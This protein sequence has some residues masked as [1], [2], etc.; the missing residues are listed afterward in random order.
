[1]RTYKPVKHMEAIQRFQ[2]C[3]RDGDHD[4]AKEALSRVNKLVRWYE[5]TE[6]RGGH[7]YIT[8]AWRSKQ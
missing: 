6:V 5:V 1:M 2:E 7:L 3:M 4:G 8:K